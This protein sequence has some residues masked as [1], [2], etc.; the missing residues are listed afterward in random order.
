M[1]VRDS[2]TYNRE[3]IV[4]KGFEVV[5]KYLLRDETVLFY[6]WCVKAR[7]KVTPVPEVLAVTEGDLGLFV[8][9]N[10]YL[11]FV[12]KSGVI[13]PT[14]SLEVRILLEKIL[15]LDTSGMV[16]KSLKITASPDGKEVEHAFLNFG[17]VKSK[18]KHY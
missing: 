3:E 15:H 2:V 14:Y 6:D 11:L 1:Q 16:I 17:S 7:R 4:D 12:Q 13:K 5:K 18:K 10:R 9:T 8:F